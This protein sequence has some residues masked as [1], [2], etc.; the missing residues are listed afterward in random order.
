MS[1]LSLDELL[2]MLREAKD[3]ERGAKDARIAIEEEIASRVEDAPDAGS[4]T[5]QGSSMRCTVKFARSYRADVERIRSL[6]VDPDL[7]PLKLKPATYELD[8]RAYEELRSSRPDVFAKVA[9]FV[10]SKPA[11]PSLV[12]KV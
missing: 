10:S 3:A 1:K 7:L 8:K 6:D 9:A 12:L 2:V 11:K 4:R 5:L